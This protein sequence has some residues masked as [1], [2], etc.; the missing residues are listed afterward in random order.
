MEDNDRMNPIE[1]AL[2]NATHIKVLK[3][4]QRASRKDWRRRE[5]KANEDDKTH[6]L[7]HTS[8][9]YTRDAS[10]AGSLAEHMLVRSN[11]CV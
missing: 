5:A 8:T 9:V 1:F 4:M 2:L 3:M 11:P 10:Y 6:L 7:Q